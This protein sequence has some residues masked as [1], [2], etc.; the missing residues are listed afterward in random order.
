[1]VKKNP[2][3]IK[4]ALIEKGVNMPCPES[5]EIG[6][7]VDPDRIAGARVVIHTGSRIF[8]PKT[9][10]L[11]GVELGTEGPVTVQDCFVGRNVRLGSGFFESSCFLEGASMGPGARYEP[12]AC[13]R[14]GLGGHTRSDSNRRSFSPTSP[15]GAS[16]T[17]VTA[18]WPGSMNASRHSGK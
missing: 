11:P 9:L 3:T 12:D 10:I 16:S 15:W 14:N 1:M 6:P 18:S 17:S 7:E 8:G 5:V 2:E 4:K 13:W